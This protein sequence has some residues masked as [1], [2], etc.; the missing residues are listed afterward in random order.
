LAPFDRALIN[1]AL[2]PREALDWLNDYHQRVRATLAA[3]LSAKA[4]AWLKTA[5]API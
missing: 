2:L 1:P 4:L 3:H 5:T